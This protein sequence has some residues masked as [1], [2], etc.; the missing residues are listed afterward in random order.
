MLT[1]TESSVFK[2]YRHEL[3][4]VVTV[5]V[6]QR[7]FFARHHNST[8]ASS[9]LLALPLTISQVELSSFHSIVFIVFGLYY[10]PNAWFIKGY[11]YDYYHHPGTSVYAV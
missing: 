9:E 11:C 4:Q 5:F 10:S 1:A 8:M 7:Q 2:E 3:V 6:N